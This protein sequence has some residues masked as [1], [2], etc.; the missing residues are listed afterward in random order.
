MSGIKSIRVAPRACKT[1]SHTHSFA[2]RTQLGQFSAL[3]NNNNNH[4][5]DKSTRKGYSYNMYHDGDTEN[6]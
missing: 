6:V 1:V 4:Q 2:R 5:H 3:H